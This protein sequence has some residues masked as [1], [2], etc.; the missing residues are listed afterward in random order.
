MKAALLS[1]ALLSSMANASNLPKELQSKIG[2]TGTLT[3]TNKGEVYEV[4]S[5]LPC[6]VAVSENSD[7]SIVL[8]ASVYFT[9]VAH[10]DEETTVERSGNKSIYTLNDSGKRPGGS[11]CGDYGILSSY[12]KTLEVTNNSVAIREKFT[13]NLFEKHDYVRICKF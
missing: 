9:P 5:N 7:S 11:A 4:E 2:K 12:K 1:I 6:E 3:T 10:L 8:E 13:C